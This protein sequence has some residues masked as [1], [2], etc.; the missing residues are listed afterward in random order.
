MTFVL[1]MFTNA[2]QCGHWAIQ[3]KRNFWA[4]YLAGLFTGPLAGG[5]MLHRTAVDA[6]SEANPGGC[7]GALAGLLIPAAGWFIWFKI[8]L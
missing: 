4:W 3:T 1:L 5:C 6:S 8:L 7:L 2:I